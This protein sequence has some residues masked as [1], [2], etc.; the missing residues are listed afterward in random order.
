MQCNLCP[1]NCKAD[2]DNGVAGYCG[3]TSDIYIAREALHMWEEPCISGERGSGAIFFTGC[4]LRCI[5][6]QNRYI[7][8][9]K[10]GYKVSVDELADSMLRLQSENANNIN[11]VTPTHYVKQIVMAIEKSKNLGLK[12]PIVYNTG[13]YENVDT[14]KM[15]EGLVDI[16][17]PDL[18][19]LDSDLAKNYSNAP[20]YPMVAKK[21]IEEMYRQCPNVVMNEKG[22]MQKG[23]IVRH[24]CLPGSYKDS[25]DIV[26]YLHETY[27]DDIYISIMN[28]Y[29][30][31]PQ[32]KGIKNLER[33]LTTYEYNKV[34]DYAIE[35]G[36]VK[37]FMQTGETAMESFIPEFYG[38]DDSV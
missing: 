31:L 25:K 24:L 1:R 21:A 13:S 19:Y 26:K 2:R 10:R 8:L 30:P 9:G 18:K 14:I 7:A 27:N 5:F 17:L 35:I 6:C 15:L 22:I 29:T 33:K 37:A 23:M 28:Q 36:V 16:Y 32:V 34:I 38:K 11:L 20:D 12:I 3:M 4:P